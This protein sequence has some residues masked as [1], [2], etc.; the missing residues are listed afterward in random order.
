MAIIQPVKGFRDFYPENWA[1]R[2]WLSD[3]WL[4]LGRL[5]GYEEYDGP[6]LEP[7]E[8]YLGKTSEEI[9]YIIPSSS[10][11][12]AFE[13]EGYD[14]NPGNRGNWSKQGHGSYDDNSIFFEGE[15]KGT[16]ITHDFTYNVN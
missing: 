1:A 14:N 16:S 8:L 15:H 9:S 12:A 6:I 7:I 10:G 2:K 5:F 11:W 13:A 3:R 4:Q